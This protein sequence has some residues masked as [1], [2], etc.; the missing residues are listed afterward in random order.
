MQYDSNPNHDAM[1]FS[2]FW[3]NTVQFNVIRSD[4]TMQM[5]DAVQFNESEYLQMK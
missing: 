4:W 2:T 3:V 1:R 5:N